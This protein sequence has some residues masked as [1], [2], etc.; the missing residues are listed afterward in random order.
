MAATATQTGTVTK[1]LLVSIEANRGREADVEAFLNA[2]LE[3]VLGEP[4][5]TAWF[6]IKLGPSTYGIF[7]V[8]PD[9]AGRDAHLGGKVAAALMENVGELYGEPTLEKLDV[10]ASKLPGSRP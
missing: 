4:A 1:G 5:T 7:D 9:E 6:A 10:L 3:I 2:G 8:F